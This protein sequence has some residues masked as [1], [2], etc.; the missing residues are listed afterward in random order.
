MK[1]KE[2][3]DASS[4]RRA[5][6]S[7]IRGSGS[8]SHNSKYKARTPRLSEGEVEGI[9]RNLTNSFLTMDTTG[10]LRP[11]NP[12]AATAQL[13]AYLLN[14]PHPPNDPRARQHQVALEALG[15]IGNKIIAPAPATPAKNQK[16]MTGKSPRSGGS[17]RQDA[18]D[19]IT[20]KKVDKNRRQGS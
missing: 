11:K 3:A 20:Q 18:I 13:A 5:E 7:T 1:R 4:Q 16:L 2:A 8:C 12:E 6:L 15:I 10:M 19:D 17:H 14:Y 9:T